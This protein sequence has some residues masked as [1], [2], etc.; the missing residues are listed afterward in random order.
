MDNA[1]SA[2]TRDVDSSSLLAALLPPPPSRRPLCY[3][4]TTSS[5]LTSTTSAA[6]NSE[7]STDYLHRAHQHHV[8]INCKLCNEESIVSYLNYTYS[9]ILL[10]PFTFNPFT[11]PGYLL[12]VTSSCSHLNTSTA[13][14]FCKILTRKRWKSE[15]GDY[16]TT[17][18]MI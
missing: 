11:V 6:L 16:Y 8:G 14:P 15:F 18:Y 13:Y 17:S 3:L 2:G 12:H 7:K 4:I 10:L 1:C 9:R 5:L